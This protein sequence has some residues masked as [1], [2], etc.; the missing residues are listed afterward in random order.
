M[1]VPMI[2][3]ITILPIAIVTLMMK[4]NNTRFGILSFSMIA[5]IKV[6]EIF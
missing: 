2:M 5:I 4:K 6:V 1:I 3:T